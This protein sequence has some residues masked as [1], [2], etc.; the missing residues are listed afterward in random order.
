MIT[1]TLTK[2]LVQ[3]EKRRVDSVNGVSIDTTWN[4]EEHVTI[5]GVIYSSNILKKGEKVCFSYQIVN[6][7]A[8]Q[9]DGGTPVHK[10]MIIHDGQELWEMDISDIFF[11]GNYEMLNSYVL[12]TPVHVEQS[13]VFGTTS[14]IQKHLGRVKGVPECL[15]SVNVGDIVCFEPKYCQKNNIHGQEHYI[16]SANRVLGKL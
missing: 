2:C 16:I 10:F 5:E 7:Y 12:L 1:P 9:P 6:E 3:I 13:N 15:K 11:K 4:R 14:T 8:K